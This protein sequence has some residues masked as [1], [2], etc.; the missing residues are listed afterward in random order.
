[1]RLIIDLWYP[2]GKSINCASSAKAA[3]SSWSH[4]TEK[5][6]L[7][8]RR[9]NLQWRRPFWKQW[10][11]YTSSIFRHAVGCVSFCTVVTLSRKHCFSLFCKTGCSN[12][13]L[14]KRVLSSLSKRLQKKCLPSTE[15]LKEYKES[16]LCLAYHDC[17]DMC[18]LGSKAGRYLHKETQ[19]HQT[20]GLWWCHWHG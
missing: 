17:R 9:L 8:I 16:H 10:L 15:C 1:M 20:T 12:W 3:A 6:A 7:H 2:K 11:W 5:E 18:K 19:F 4:Y 13:C 14:H